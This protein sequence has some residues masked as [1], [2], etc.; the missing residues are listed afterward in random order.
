MVSVLPVPLST[1]QESGSEKTKI[2][3]SQKEPSKKRVENEK[4]CPADAVSE[5]KLPQEILD[6]SKVK[7]EKPKIYHSKI[8]VTQIFQ[9]LLKITGNNDLITELQRYLSDNQLTIENL[10]KNWKQVHPTSENF[11][12]DNYRNDKLFH[13]MKEEYDVIKTKSDGSCLFRAIATCIFGDEDKQLEL[14]LLSI[15]SMLENLDYFQKNF[16]AYSNTDIEQTLTDT[17]NYQSNKDAGWG[18]NAHIKALSII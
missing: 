7:V 13:A 10:T 11:N 5:A 17:I 15:I 6:L 14:R 12:I 4:Y 18:T 8:N 9:D 16:A 3:F 1:L 2:G